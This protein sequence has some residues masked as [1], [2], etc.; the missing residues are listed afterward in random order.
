M[1]QCEGRV[2]KNKKKN[3]NVQMGWASGEIAYHIVVFPVVL[4]GSL[5]TEGVGKGLRCIDGVVPG[6]KTELRGEESRLCLRADG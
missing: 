3:R 5:E 1:Q 4:L 6:G 2:L